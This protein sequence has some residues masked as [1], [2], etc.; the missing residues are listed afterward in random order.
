MLFEEQTPVAGAQKVAE[1]QGWTLL[2]LSVAPPHTGLMPLQLEELLELKGLPEAKSSPA[3]VSVRLF[4]LL[5]T[6]CFTS[7][8]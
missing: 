5:S 7:F 4:S 8:T 2:L 6:A 3:G 1:M